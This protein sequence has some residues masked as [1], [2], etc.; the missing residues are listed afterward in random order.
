MATTASLSERPAEG[1]AARLAALAQRAFAEPLAPSPWD[2]QPIREELFSVE[3][4]E[5]HA[6]AFAA[7]Q[8]PSARRARGDSL[9]RRLADN[10]PALVA[11]YRDVADAVETG[12]PI[13]PAAEWLID[14][15]HVV[16]E[17]IREARADLRAATTG[18]CRSSAQSLLRPATRIRP[19]L[20]VRRPHRQPV[21]S[22]GVAPLRARLPRGAATD[23][24][25]AVG[26]RDHAAHRAG[27]KPTAHRDP[28]DRQPG[29]NYADAVA[30]RLLGAGASRP[31]RRPTSWRART[32]ALDR[33]LLRR[34]GAA[35]ARPGPQCRPRPRLDR[36]KGGSP[37]PDHD[38]VVQAEHQRQVAGSITVRNVI[39]SM[40]LISDVD[41]SELVERFSR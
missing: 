29:G 35:T 32:G 16:E 26:R 41:W 36:R 30:D 5:E 20:G 19:G 39:T 24:R 23:H 10:E 27:G 17:Q 37:G 12:A 11:A 34:T 40:R 1:R 7:T 21:R 6:R 18:S 8:T 13:T 31:S 33:S 25:R 9:S 15:F 22:G 14:N 2:E 3:R 38:G 28:G 4:L